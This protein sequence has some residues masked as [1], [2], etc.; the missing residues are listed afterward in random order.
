[1]QEIAHLATARKPALDALS[2][3][4]SSFVTFCTRLAKLPHPGV[5]LEAL[6]M[7]VRVADAYPKLHVRT[8]VLSVM[9]SV[10]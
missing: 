7:L 3:Y 8:D 5:A 10:L 6:R 2:P 1:M 9:A 4:V